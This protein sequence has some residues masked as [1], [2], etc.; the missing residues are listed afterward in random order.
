MENYSLSLALFDF[1]PVALSILGLFWLARCMSEVLPDNRRILLAGVALVG[2]GGLSKA[3]WKLIWVTTQ[4]DVVLLNNLLFILMA[5]GF[6]ILASHCHSARRCW[7]GGQRRNHETAVGVIL[8][9]LLLGAAA[10]IARGDGNAWFFTLLAG[11]SISNILISS[12]MINLS[13][14]KRQRATAGLF[15]LSITLILSLSGL[16]RISA[17]SAPL[18]WLAE[19][20]NTFAHGSFALAMWR[21]R[22]ILIQAA[23]NTPSGS[24]TLK[25]NSEQA[26]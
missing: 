19:I 20:L 18:Q 22:P 7:L 8:S 15:L 4:T 12:W 5:P 17:G 1:L 9:A 14:R 21:L 13:W 6:I 11:A 23:A 3:S 25:T 26:L 10:M 2:A 16:S 24:S